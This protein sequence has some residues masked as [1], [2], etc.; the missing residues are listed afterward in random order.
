MKLEIGALLVMP[1][2][3]RTPLLEQLESCCSAVLAAVN[4]E[5]A[6]RI[7]Q[8]Y[9]ALDVVVTEL[10][11][12]DGSWWTIHQELARARVSTALVVC[13]PGA[14]GGISDILERGADDVLLPPYERP[15]IQRMLEAAAARSYMRTQ[16]SAGLIF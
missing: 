3:H 1:R 12:E 15:E 11:L 6:R 4:C 14:D 16:H 9:P 2:Y 7:L 8:G 5:E 10:S 13:L